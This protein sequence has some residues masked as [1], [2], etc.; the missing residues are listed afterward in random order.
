MTARFYYPG[1]MIPGQIITLPTNTG[2]HATRVLRL[3]QGDKVILFNGEG[4]EFSGSIHHLDKSASTVILSEFH[5]I[6]RESP[7]SI[8]LI[9]AV[10]SNEKMDWIIQKSVELGV[11]CI[12]PVT[13][14]RSV[15]RLSEERANK[16]VLHWQQVIIAACEQC[17][18]NRIPKLYP[19]LTLSDWFNQEFESKRN[20][21]ENQSI[22]KLLLS[23]TANRRLSKF[24]LPNIDTP[25]SLLV[26]PEGGFTTEEEKAAHA[27]GF[28]PICLGQRTLR[29][30]TAALT[31]IATMQALWGDY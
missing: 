19:L 23:L 3:K 16:R 12:Q 31:A 25:L 26:G 20:N 22:Y 5:A 6:E 30:E 2:H 7:L 21:I 28:V 29:T 10:C 4:G 1:P 17:G 24:S 15:V 14:N 13:A 8:S 27:M 9:Q 11:N 18:R